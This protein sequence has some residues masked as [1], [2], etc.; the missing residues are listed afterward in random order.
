LYTWFDMLVWVF[1]HECM[2]MHEF[3]CMDAWKCMS[4]VLSRHRNTW[5]CWLEER[6][7]CGMLY[8]SGPCEPSTRENITCLVRS[9]RWASLI[10][11]KVGAPYSMP[12]IFPQSFLNSKYFC[13]ISNAFYF[14]CFNVWLSENKSMNVQ[15]KNKQANQHNE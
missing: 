7:P 13:L 11:V 2:V 1:I 3:M 10:C 8:T 4:L 5:Y 6:D 12:L 14:Q 9:K 15:E